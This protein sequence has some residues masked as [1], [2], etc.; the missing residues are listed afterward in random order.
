MATVRG[1]SPHSEKSREMEVYPI[2][3]FYI[4]SNISPFLGTTD[5]QFG[6]QLIGSRFFCYNSP[7]AVAREVF[8]PSTDAESLLGSI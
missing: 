6:C 8:K 2:V 4:L 3:D 1:P 7:A 5:D